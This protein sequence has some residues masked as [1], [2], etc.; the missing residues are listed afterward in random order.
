MYIYFVI[1][2][3]RLLLILSMYYV[4]PIAIICILNYSTSKSTSFFTVI[5]PH[6]YVTINRWLI[7]GVQGVETINFLN[8]Y[9]R[10]TFQPIRREIPRANIFIKES[11]RK[12]PVYYHRERSRRLVQSLSSRRSLNL[13]TKEIILFVERRRKYYRNNGQW[14]IK[15]H[16]RYARGML[17]SNVART[18]WNSSL[19]SVSHS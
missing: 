7:Y 8:G 9:S 1:L 13:V 15:V 19:M 18:P 11:R 14:T 4:W 6:V 16:G 12:S 5:A 17:Q 2:T 10:S 3:H